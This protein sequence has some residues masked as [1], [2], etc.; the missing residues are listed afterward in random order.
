[1]TEQ[2]YEPHWDGSRTKYDRETARRYDRQRYGGLRGRIKNWLHARILRRAFREVPSGSLVLDVPCGTGRFTDWLCGRGY[3]V[4]GVDISTEMIDVA[5]EKQ[6]G[7]LGYVTADVLHLPYA[8]KSVDATLTVR[9]FH[10]V[11][12]WMRVDVYQELAR[13]TRKRVVIGINCNKW[14]LKTLGRRLRGWTSNYWM[15]RSELTEELEHGGLEVLRIHS[16][17][18]PLSTLWVV[19]CRPM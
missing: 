18:G 11:P 4:V 8:D 10:L 6:A 17:G 12:S 7:A 3:R 15:S 14:A 13:V 19:V 16:K 1:M 2:V 5:R 9:F